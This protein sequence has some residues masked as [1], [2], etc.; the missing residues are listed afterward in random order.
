MCARA[1]TRMR[2]CTH[3]CDCMYRTGTVLSAGSMRVSVACCV[4]D[5]CTRVFHAFMLVL[6]GTVVSRQARDSSQGGRGWGRRRAAAGA[7]AQVSVQARG[8]E[9]SAR[10]EKHRAWRAAGARGSTGQGGEWQR[11]GGRWRGRAER[12]GQS[13][14]AG[15]RAR[16]A[17]T[18]DARAGS[19][20]LGRVQ[21]GSCER[22]AHGKAKELRRAPELYSGDFFSYLCIQPLRGTWLG[23][24]APPSF[25]Q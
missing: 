17:G 8:T 13:K 4:R 24:R 10:G 12:A 20:S 25:G 6:R 3:A 22:T 9:R 21:G 2:A 18:R 15:G 16:E 23:S 14:W 7:G 5:V 19:G 1:R 11:R